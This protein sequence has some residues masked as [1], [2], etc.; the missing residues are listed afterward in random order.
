MSSGPLPPVPDLIPIAALLKSP[1]NNGRARRECAPC[2]AHSEAM[3]EQRSRRTGSQPSADLIDSAQSRGPSAAPQ[4]PQS[5]K[6]RSE[7]HRKSDRRREHR[8][9]ARTRSGSKHSP[10][11]RDP[12]T[13]A[14]SP[15]RPA[16]PRVNP[17]FV[18]VRQE[19]TRIVDVKCEDYDKR[20]RI[21]LTKTAQGWRAIPRTETLVPTLKEAAEAH[22]HHHHHHR[23]RK[24]RKTKV[25]RRSAAVQVD[26]DIQLDQDDDRPPSPTWTSPVN[27]E[28]HLPSHKIHVPKKC[29]SP[30]P[31]DSPSVNSIVI[32]S[33]QTQDEKCSAAKI[34]DVSPLD[35]LLAVAEFEFNQH[36]QSGE[37]EK[38]PDN[39]DIDDEQ[40]E[41]IN[42]MEQLNNL[43]ESCSKTDDK[44]EHPDFDGH[45]TKTEDCDYTEDDDNNLAMDDILSRL[46]QSLRSPE[47]PEITEVL[48]TYE[49]KLEDIK[50]A[51]CFDSDINENNYKS[52]P[53]LE[54]FFEE[55]KTTTDKEADPDTPNQSPPE[56]I[57]ESSTTNEDEPTD[58]SIKPKYDDNECNNVN[59]VEQP[60]DLSVP[61][62]PNTASP[63]RSSTPRPPSQNSEAIQ[64]PQPSGIPAVPPSP[65][66]VSTSANN[67]KNKSVFLESLLT[68]TSQKIALNSEVTIIKQ[69]EPLDLGKCRKSAS[70]TVTCSEEV[71]N[72]GDDSEPPTKKFKS[73]DLT[74]KNLLDLEMAKS[75][76]E[77]KTTE[78]SSVPETPRLLE[79][80][81]TDSG[82]DPLT[83]LRQILYDTNLNIPD[84]MLVP[85]ERL[86]QIISH[87]G[88]EIPR[89]LKQRPEL[90][91]PEALAFPHLLQDPD[92]L[93]IT[94][95]QLE[96]I[97]LKQNQSLNLREM[98]GTNEKS[99]DKG[100]KRPEKLPE[101]S[102][103]SH[104]KKKSLDESVSKLM[105]SVQESLP[106]SGFNELA[107]DID[108]ATTAAFNQMIWLPYLNQLEAMSFGSNPEMMKMLSNSLPMYPGQ[109]P[110][111]NH[112]IGANRFPPPV[113]FPMQQ[114][115]VNYNSLEL[116]MW[117][118]AMMQ[119]NMLRPKH[120]FEGLNQKNSFRDYLDKMNFAAS[121]KTPLNNHKLPSTLMNKPP[122][123]NFYPSGTNGHAPF[124]NSFLNGPGYQSNSSKQN[125]QIPHFN[126][127]F[128]QKNLQQKPPSHPYLPKKFDPK[129]N[130]SSFYHQRS[131]QKQEHKQKVS[132]KSFANVSYQRHSSSEQRDKNGDFSKHHSQ[133]IDLSGSTAPATKLKVKQ[134]LID[135]ANA[136]KLLKHDDVP[137]VGS[138]TASVEEMQDAHKHLWHPLFGN[139]K[140]Y[141]SPWNWT[142]VTAT[143]E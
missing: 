18:W 23:N 34:C 33:A 127:L 142:T 75:G 140:G 98:K 111:L 62:N 80:L 59:D 92:I 24:S 99:Q 41:F 52:V 97:I 57:V 26:S 86:S 21:L 120:P 139:Q 9:P 49:T 31:S 22:H 63:V 53:E 89:L 43:I 20:N 129:P 109:L 45:P 25:R 79:L 135:P 108:A 125:L 8:K 61:K 81:K 115:Q 68:T 95:Q 122:P 12:S 38:T 83:Q 137:E 143:G 19:D 117:Q 96:T 104:S 1:N 130:F 90:R 54:S 7:R 4:P 119:A 124:P 6:A 78:K 56:D 67:C 74:L 39:D 132:C 77:S 2:A 116:S 106:K 32:D 13:P 138:T 107:S 70:P 73:G 64:S 14:S 84:P 37:W 27:V 72:G 102:K 94:L 40:K 82:P 85:K 114:P 141:H 3:G 134:H 118:E 100:T 51:D 11:S 128:G 121:A 93:V 110:D 136:S 123:N 133:P 69:K 91:L 5:R 103:D 113:N 35:N 47:C 71:K 44:D 42:N 15:E 16:N 50:E 48:N 65:D 55:T 88:R 66:I 58:L 105:T 87:P 29:P 126:P 60:T 10:R 17:I 30:S 131:D 46:E 28:S 36:M 112:L 101:S 76:A